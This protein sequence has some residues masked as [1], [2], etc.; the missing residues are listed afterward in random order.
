M[1]RNPPQP[2]RAEV[3]ATRGSQAQVGTVVVALQRVISA[4]HAASR[5]QRDKIRQARVDG[6]YRADMAVKLIQL[7]A[8]EEGVRFAMLVAQEAEAEARRSARAGAA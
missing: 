1:P 7:V 5:A 6:A 8:Y 3:S 2:Y 4:A